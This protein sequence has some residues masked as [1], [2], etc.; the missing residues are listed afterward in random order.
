M[1][2]NFHLKHQKGELTLPQTSQR[3]NVAGQKDLGWCKRKVE[4]KKRVWQANIVSPLSL[5]AS[6]LIWPRTRERAPK[7]REG[8]R[9]LLSPASSCSIS[10]RVPL[11]CLLFTISPKWRACSQASHHSVMKKLNYQSALIGATNGNRPHSTRSAHWPKYN[12]IS[13]SLEQECGRQRYAT[14]QRKNG[15]MSRV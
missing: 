1:I 13:N 15:G 3:K 12:F 5:W 2:P 10:S 11:A 4:I 7:R 8:P 14:R 9:G 6:S